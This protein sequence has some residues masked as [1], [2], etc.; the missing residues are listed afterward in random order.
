MH[1]FVALL[2]VASGAPA[3]NA[4]PEKLPPT[5]RAHK[6]PRV[7]GVV[8]EAPRSTCTH[9]A[10]PEAE[11]VEVEVYAGNFIGIVENPI[12][13]HPVRVYVDTFE[14]D[15]AELM[16][17][18]NEGFIHLQLPVG[19]TVFLT[20]LAG[21]GYVETSTAVS[22]V[23]AEGLREIMGR[24]LLQVPTDIVYGLF[25]L[26]IGRPTPANTCQVVATM[27]HNTTYP[28]PSQGWDGVEAT[29]VPASYAVGDATLLFRYVSRRK[30]QPTPKQS[31]DHL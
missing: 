26:L 5:P 25:K 19:A 15:K 10:S 22:T 20:I 18:D 29:I 12:R 30:H 9:K 16:A 28:Y 4:H 21:S 3:L 2:F 6:L 13:N 8:V 17:T 11:L 7:G 14:D 24:I 23:P 1:C 31:N 27:R